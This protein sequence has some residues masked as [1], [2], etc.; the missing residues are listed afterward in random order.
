MR[1]FGVPMKRANFSD[2]TPKVSVEKDEGRRISCRRTS[3]GVSTRTVDEARRSRSAI[4]GH[5]VPVL[6][7]VL[8][9]DVVEDVVDGDR[10]EQVLLLVHHRGGDEVVRRERAGDATE[11][12]LGT[13]GVDRLVDVAA[14]ALVRGLTEEPLDVDH[15]EVLPRG[16]LQRG[17]AD[18]HG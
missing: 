15:P 7:P 9:E 10:A 11:R 2:K 3:W 13:K 16:G 5:L 12:L 1:N 8:R 6:A 18:V 17:A 4:L 14:D